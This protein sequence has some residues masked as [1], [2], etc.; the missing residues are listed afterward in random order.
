MAG[1]WRPERSIA[2]GGQA[3]VPEPPFAL[4][5]GPVLQS[6][7]A[8]DLLAGAWSH[9]TTR[10]EQLQASGGTPAQP[11]P[12]DPALT[13]ID[14]SP[15]SPAAS[16]KPVDL[17]AIMVEQAALAGICSDTSEQS[18]ASSVDSD[19]D[20]APLELRMPG[21]A[22]KYACSGPWGAGTQC[23]R[24]LSKVSPARPVGSRSAW[25]LNSQIA[26]MASFVNARHVLGFALH[27]TRGDSM[28]NRDRPRPALAW[29]QH[30]ALHI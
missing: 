24:T 15:D 4:P 19:N 11:V 7:R 30:V 9:F 8:S 23:A 27:E 2:R 28:Q 25:R 18:S 3:P 14:S 20:Q 21:S 29:H 13:Q 10:H 17:E 22:A 12:S 16:P 6:L 26:R 1:G 5:P